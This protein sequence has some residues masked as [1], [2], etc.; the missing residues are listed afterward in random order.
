MADEALTGQT[1]EL[2]QTLIRNACVNDGSPDSG[3]ESRSA[4]VL[5]TFLE[6][7]GLDVARY[8]AGCLLVVDMQNPGEGRVFAAFP[9]ANSPLG[10]DQFFP[11]L[12][13]TYDLRYPYVAESMPEARRVVWDPASSAFESLSEQATQEVLG[14]SPR[15][16]AEEPELRDLE[17]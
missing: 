9:A 15:L 13:R 14:Y 1:I 16:S 4:D 8:E 2:L 10:I 5:Q 7:A 12:Y 6:G 17:E 3:F 11:T